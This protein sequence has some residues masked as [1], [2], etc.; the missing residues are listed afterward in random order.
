M[1]NGKS[2]FGLPRVFRGK[3]RPKQKL[4][5]RRV[6]ALG[7]ARLLAVIAMAR[8][9]TPQALRIAIQGSGVSAAACAERL[10]HKHDVTGD[11][12]FMCS[13]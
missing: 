6:K 7:I 2:S 10:R 4:C 12:C 11:Q 13:Q 3:A 5:M 1:T 9:P 8:V